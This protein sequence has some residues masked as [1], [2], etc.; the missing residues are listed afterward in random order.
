MELL[1]VVL[2]IGLLGA[3]ALAQYTL[4]VQKSRAV[5]AF[6]SLRTLSAAV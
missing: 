2:I 1:V 3:V 4:A 5:E 6:V